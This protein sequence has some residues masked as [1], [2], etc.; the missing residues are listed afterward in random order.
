MLQLHATD[1]SKYNSKVPK[2]YGCYSVPRLA[3]V[4]TIDSLTVRVD[5]SQT[6]GLLVS[7]RLT[8][9]AA[10][11]WPGESG[12][13]ISR[14][15]SKPHLSCPASLCSFST[16]DKTLHKKAEIDFANFVQSVRLYETLQPVHPPLCYGCVGKQC[17][18]HGLWGCRLTSSIPAQAEF[19]FY[20]TTE[21]LQTSITLQDGCFGTATLMRIAALFMRTPTAPPLPS[22]E[23]PL[24]AEQP[25]SPS[26]HPTQTDPSASVG[27]N[28]VPSTAQSVLVNPA[29]DEA[30]LRK[31][32]DSEVV[33]EVAPYGH[34][35]PTDPATMSS[36]E[37]AS[38]EAAPHRALPVGEP[39]ADST[40]QSLSSLPSVDNSGRSADSDPGSSTSAQTGPAQDPPPARDEPLPQ[41]DGHP[42]AQDMSLV[43]GLPCT[44]VL[45]VAQADEGLLGALQTPL[46]SPQEGVQPQRQAAAL[47]E[48]A[49][50]M[51]TTP[52]TS[53]VFPND[54]GTGMVTIGADQLS[55]ANEA[56]LT[57]SSEPEPHTPEE[58]DAEEESK[59]G[60]E[61]MEQF[62]LEIVRCKIVCPAQV[63]TAGFT[64]ADPSPLDHT[65]YMEI[66][67]FLLQLPLVQ[68]A[69][70]PRPHAVDLNIKQVL[71][72]KQAA[73]P[74]PDVT[75]PSPFAATGQQGT[76]FSLRNLAL[77]VALPEEFESAHLAP[78]DSASHAQLPPFLSIPTASLSA[79]PQRAPPQHPALQSHMPDEPV[80]TLELEIRTAE[81][82]AKPAQLQTVSASTLRYS[83]EMDVILGRPPSDPAGPGF[84]ATADPDLAS[85]HSQHPVSKPVHRPGF[86]MEASVGLIN[87]QLH[88]SNKLLPAL[89]LQWQRL[90]SHWSQ[91]AGSSVGPAHSACGVTW[92]FLSLQLTDNPAEPQQQF[93]LEHV[94]TLRSGSL[95]LPGRMSR[96]HSE[97]LGG[98]GPPS[99]SRSSHHGSGRLNRGSSVHGPSR[100][101]TAMTRPISPED[102]FPNHQQHLS[103]LH[104]PPLGNGR[105]GHGLT[106][107]AEIA[108]DDDASLPSSPQYIVNNR[109]RL[110]SDS[111]AEAV[112]GVLPSLSALSLNK[113]SQQQQ[114]S[115]DN[116]SSSFSDSQSRSRRHH[117]L[118]RLHSLTKGT[119]IASSTLSLG[120][121]QRQVPVIRH[122]SVM[123][124]TAPSTPHAEAPNLPPRFA[125]ASSA[126]NF[127]SFA[128]PSGQGLSM[129]SGNLGSSAGA[130]EEGAPEDSFEAWSANDLPQG[131]RLLLVLGSKSCF[132]TKDSS[133]Q[134]SADASVGLSLRPLACMPDQSSS[135]NSALEICASDMLLRVFLEVSVALSHCRA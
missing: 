100:R 16:C 60:P 24:D 66:P 62:S 82:I 81:V 70:H 5:H 9:A 48:A 52:D 28:P 99:S 135:A 94:G 22:S 61:R 118:D 111:F 26:K 130:F 18:S 49:V 42:Q 8:G 51:Q 34:A 71:K 25:D 3:Q 129:F 41:A 92:Q 10:R 103:N 102:D 20:D 96:V 21:R 56:D 108:A 1:R 67:H 4:M 120:E 127:S 87:L 116:A 112:E 27:L 45:P 39:V 19:T 58:S 40:S 75:S 35:Q 90:S 7:G 80:P 89:V 123:I 54:S 79:V 43:S 132:A 72:G 50:V 128:S 131:N 38:Q 77:F 113:A 32:E 124:A 64:D 65:L 98:H 11:G 97:P 114:G 115:S 57:G 83:T 37:S 53:L 106:G 29:V 121:L 74:A 36:S 59:A 105:S 15:K 13:I 88:S 30:A 101:Q 125:S 107:L 78:S 133:A 55:I 119:S 44:S 76:I 68:P 85:G 69:Q 2:I 63:D 122:R 23:A 46:G 33:S 12:N 73:V 6:N 93:S 110:A 31:P 91:A 117:G 47:V 109:A 126:F 17:R 95:A 14:Y 84:A 86:A 104:F 134:T